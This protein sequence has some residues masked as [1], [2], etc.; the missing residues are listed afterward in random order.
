MLHSVHRTRT[1]GFYE[2][3]AKNTKDLTSALKTIQSIA[4]EMGAFAFTLTPN[5]WAITTMTFLK[6]Q[7][8]LLLLLHGIALWLW[9]FHFSFIFRAAV[10]PTNT[11]FQ[12]VLAVNVNLCYQR[13]VSTCNLIVAEEMQKI[14]AVLTRRAYT[15]TS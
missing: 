1:F 9:H 6:V 5:A 14:H 3:T 11:S 2:T 4:L 13:Y 8:F 15:T 12:F 7:I 10:E